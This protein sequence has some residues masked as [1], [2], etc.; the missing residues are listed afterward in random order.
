MGWA[1]GDKLEVLIGTD[2]DHGL[3]R[4]RK[5][6]SA[7]DA[8]VRFKKAMKG[9]TYAT[10]NLGH[11]AKFVNRAEAGRWCQHEEVEDGYLEIVLPRWADETAPKKASQAPAAAPVRPTGQSGPALPTTSA[12]V[13][14]GA[15]MGDPPAGRREMLA[16]I[17]EM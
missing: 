17:G 7:G 13:V 10:I 16:K 6:N 15:L 9:I 14:T 4:F 2:S 11:Q 8:V 1:E 3:L 5:N 12:K